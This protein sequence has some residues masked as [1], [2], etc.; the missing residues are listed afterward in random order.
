MTPAVEAILFLK[1]I[2]AE[3]SIGYSEYT[4]KW[5]MSD[6]IEVGGDGMLASPTLHRD[7]P[8]AAVVDL[9]EQYKQDAKFLGQKYLVTRYPERRHWQ[10]NGACFVQIGGKNGKDQS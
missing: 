6:D 4:N 10:W 1:A 3:P 2:G 8:E 7:T 5:Y 9:F